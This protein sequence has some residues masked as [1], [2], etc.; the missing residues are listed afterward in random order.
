M[1]RMSM[2]ILSDFIGMMLQYALYF[3]KTIRMITPR[4]VNT[5]YRH[6]RNCL[7]AG[8]KQAKIKNKRS[9]HSFALVIFRGI[10]LGCK[11]TSL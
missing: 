6:F 3:R 4:I 1:E 10:S 2:N 9:P 5:S 8:K 7:A 11:G